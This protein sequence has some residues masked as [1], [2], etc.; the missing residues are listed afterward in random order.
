VTGKCFKCRQPAAYEWRVCSDGPWRKV[1][2][3][4]DLELNKIALKWAFPGQ[5]RQKFEKYRRSAE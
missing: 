1:C 2:K 4:C 3:D 5:W